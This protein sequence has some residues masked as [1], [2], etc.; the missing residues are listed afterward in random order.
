M[1]PLRRSGAMI[2]ATVSIVALAGLL[3]AAAPASAQTAGAHKPA[4]PMTSPRI[5]PPMPMTMPNPTPITTPSGLTII[6]TTVG[7]GAAPRPG[8]TCVM[9][10][11]GWLYVNG[12]KGNKFDS[13]RDHGQPFEFKL[14][15]HQVFHPV[16][17]TAAA[18]PAA[19]FRR[20]P[21]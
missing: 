2:A 9:H 19:S 10:Y 20:M 11:T 12:K 1:R 6:D 4:T 8:Q 5:P 15:A 7:D 21:R 13:S 16:S 18:A 3:D 14:G 17:A